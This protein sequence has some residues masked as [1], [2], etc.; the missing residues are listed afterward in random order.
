MRGLS[1]SRRVVIHS[2]DDWV[3]VLSLSSKSVNMAGKAAREGAVDQEATSL[4]SNSWGA[5]KNFSGRGKETPYKI[6]FRAS[7]LLGACF[8]GSGGDIGETMDPNLVC[9]AA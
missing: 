8:Y 2:R 6:G 1:G 7:G 4:A 9:V 5:A 3:Y